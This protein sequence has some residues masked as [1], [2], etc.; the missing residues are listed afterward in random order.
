MEINKYSST[1]L[2]LQISDLIK[3]KIEA[4]TFSTNQLLPSE[5]EIQKQYSVSRITARKA[6]NTLMEQG[7]IRAV[8]GKGTYVNDLRNKDWT[9]MKYFTREVKSQGHEPSSRIL[10]FKEIQANEEIAGILEIPK[11]SPV[12]YLKRVRCIDNVPVWLTRSYIPVEIA[13]GLS[14]E[15]FSEKGSAQSIFFIL[16]T[17]FGIEF[18]SG[19]VIDYLSEVPEKDLAVLGIDQN[20]PLE[21]TAFVRLN[22][23]EIPVIYEKTIF[24][25]TIAK[26]VHNQ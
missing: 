8:R 19:R 24:E 16:E 3:E 18:A 9:W 7:I 14:R 11:L 15:Y 4:G 12:Y 25:Q 13:P 23:D 20:K 6:Y 2:Y 22:T 10:G 1:P 21:K 5:M 17:D 26:N